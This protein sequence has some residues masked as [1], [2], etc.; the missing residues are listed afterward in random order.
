MLVYA[1]FLKASQR[2]PLQRQ[3]PLQAML[4]MMMMMMKMVV[5]IT[6]TT[7]VAIAM[8]EWAAIIVSWLAAF[9]EATR[10]AMAVQLIKVIAKGS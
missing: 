8:E 4:M 7:T 9:A 2:F 6:T 5:K 3:H 1:R 10:I